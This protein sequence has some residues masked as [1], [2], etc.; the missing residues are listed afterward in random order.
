MI[1]L[2]GTGFKHLQGLGYD[3]LKY[4]QGLQGKQ[5]WQL[6]TDNIVTPI[7]ICTF[8]W[9]M[10]EIKLYVAKLQKFAMYKRLYSKNKGIHKLH[11]LLQD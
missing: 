7:I 3:S 10:M 5:V 2:W 9:Q 8:W 11:L 1:K 4:F 6:Y